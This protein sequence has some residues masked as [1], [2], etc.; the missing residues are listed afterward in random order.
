MGDV[1]IM[2]GEYGWECLS[3]RDAGRDV[4]RRVERRWS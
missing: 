2:S 4:E 1:A 3:G